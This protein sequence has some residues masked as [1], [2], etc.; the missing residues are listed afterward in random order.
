MH[1]SD[2]HKNFEH[3]EKC[4]TLIDKKYE[5]TITRFKHLADKLTAAEVILEDEISSK[6]FSK[7]PHITLKLE[8]SKAFHSIKVIADDNIPWIDLVKP[9]KLQGSVSLLS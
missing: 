7:V 6:I 8:N 3:W 9:I 1:S 5:I 2:Y 4:C